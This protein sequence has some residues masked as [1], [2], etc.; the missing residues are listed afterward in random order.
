[1]DDR[2]VSARVDNGVLRLWREDGTLV[3]LADLTSEELAALRHGLGEQAIAS[4]AYESL[5]GVAAVHRQLC[6]DI[7]GMQRKAHAPGARISDWVD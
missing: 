4:A 5:F 2:H 1:M 3:E 6:L 7:E